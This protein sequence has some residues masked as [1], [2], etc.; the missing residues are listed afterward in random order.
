MKCFLMIYIFF[1]NFI[2]DRY[3][4]KYCKYNKVKN[5][6]VSVCKIIIVYKLMVKF[7]IIMFV[8]LDYKSIQ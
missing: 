1:L 3:R 5:I 6:K 2:Q 4:Y 7:D 8:I